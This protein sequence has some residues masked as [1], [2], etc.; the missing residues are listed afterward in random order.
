MVDPGDFPSGYKAVWLFVLFDIPVKTRI[1][2][3]R[4]AAFRKS[5]LQAGFAQLQ[6]SVYARYFP[7]EAACDPE[8]K[9]ISRE[10]PLDSHVR[11]LRITDRQFGKMENFFGRKKVPIEDKPDQLLLF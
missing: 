8:R 5:L 10:I 4:Y 1:E 9:R 11:L 7:S 2:R 6:Y 3:R